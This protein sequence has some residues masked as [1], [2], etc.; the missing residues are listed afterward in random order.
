MALTTEQQ[1][2]LTAF[3]HFLTVYQDQFFRLGGFSGCGKT[4]LSVEM[5]E[6]VK[7]AI[8]VYNLINSKRDI[9][10]EICATTN[11]AARVLENRMGIPVSTIYSALKINL[12]EC[13]KTGREL[14]N[15]QYC[16]ISKKEV[17]YFIDECSYLS[18]EMIEA[19]VKY[20]PNSKFVLIGDQFQLPPIGILNAPAFDLNC[21]HAELSQVQRSQ[22]AIQQL[23]YD[24]KEGVRRDRNV[25]IIGS[26]NEIVVTNDGNEF[27]QLIHDEFSRSDFA[28]GDAVVLGYRNNHMRN[29]AS[30]IRSI[31]GKQEL[32]QTGDMVMVNSTYGDI[33]TDALV[34]VNSIKVAKKKYMDLETYHI[35]INGMIT[36]Y[37]PEHN[38]LDKK[39]KVLARQCSLGELHWKEYFELKNMFVDLRD[40][41]AI[42]IHKSQGSTYPTVF[43]D[44]NDLTRCKSIGLR[45][46]LKYVGA[47]RAS[48]KLVVFN[49]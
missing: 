20:R 45:K 9:S 27:E 24:L 22:G 21:P 18:N 28:L 32:F 35:N 1:N 26:G 8:Q 30:S 2:A 44:L 13:H 41:N 49:G 29:I 19:L 33:P 16:S 31:Q 12:R 37:T 48:H 4:Y 15:Y 39:L 14:L 43:L 36:L 34:K 42:T 47:S 11:K 3:E 17:I 10:Y 7:K 23:T 6:S 25:P 5:L 38:R 46:R 40:P